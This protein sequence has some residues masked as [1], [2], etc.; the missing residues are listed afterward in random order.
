M[1]TYWLP[2]GT[3][4][5]FSKICSEYKSQG[6]PFLS[7]SLFLSGASIYWLGRPYENE[8]ISTHTH[9]YIKR[10]SEKL[11]GML[12]A[13]NIPTLPEQDQKKPVV[14]F[15]IENI[16]IKPRF[17]PFNFCLN[18]HKRMFSDVFLF[19]LAHIYELV[20]ISSL[21]DE[22]VYKQVDPYGCISYRLFVPNKKLFEPRHL[23]RKL[24]K[25]V[26]IASKENEYS[27]KFHDN[28][29]NI[30]SWKGISDN[31]LLQVLDFLVNL[32][33]ANISD[34][35]KTISSYRQKDFYE[36]FSKVHKNI[37]FKRN[38]LS[39]NLENKYKSTVENINKCRIMEFKRAEVVMEENIAKYEIENQRSSIY[40]KVSDFVKGVLF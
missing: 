8:K 23:N 3:T 4:R 29:L 5:L 20:S 18:T 32:Y 16:L 13:D 25:V 9:S 34:W 35:R 39:F 24:E 7:T 33:F 36:T 40:E 10:A 38:F 6:F 37:F 1:H 15:D 12:K 28:I 26:C 2:S 17:F 30:G 22:S 27:H 11:L 31:R 19:H 21:D 14:L